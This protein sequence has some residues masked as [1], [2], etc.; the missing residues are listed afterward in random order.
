MWCRGKRRQT[1]TCGT[2][3]KWFHWTLLIQ[4]DE[5]WKSPESRT[6][7]NIVCKRASWLQS[8]LIESS[9]CVISNKRQTVAWIWIQVVVFLSQDLPVLQLPSTILKSMQLPSATVFSHKGDPRW[10]HAIN[11]LPC[12][13]AWSPLPGIAEDLPERMTSLAKM[14]SPTRKKWG[15]SGYDE[16]EIS[17]KIFGTD[18][19]EAFLSRF[20]PILGVD[21]K[22]FHW[23][24]HPGRPPLIPFRIDTKRRCVKARF[25]LLS[26]NS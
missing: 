12:W 25:L 7:I 21:F 17:I 4:R 9:K 14:T 19:S 11:G 18:F 5:H 8:E 22:W 26:G 13:S 24:Y 20:L 10:G 15:C 1:L 23:F 2:K 16:G 6:Y 3:G